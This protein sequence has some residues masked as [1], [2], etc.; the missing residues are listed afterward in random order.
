MG[1]L[2]PAAAVLRDLQRWMDSIPEHLRVEA[3]DTTRPAFQRP[4][5]VLHAMFHYTVTV[6][7]R[8]AL[9]ARASI[10]AKEGQDSTNP[11]LISMARSYCESGRDLG[12]IL[13]RLESFGKFDAVTTCDIWYTLASSS[14]LVLD[15]VCLDK[16]ADTDS[17]ES[18]VL[19]SQLA[20]LAQR[21]RRNPYMPGTIEKFAS[22][23]PELHSMA[24]SPDFSPSSAIEPGG[25]ANTTASGN[26][27]HAQ[28]QQQQD[29]GSYPYLQSSTSNGAYLFA[30]NVPG[31]FQ[32]EQAYAGNAV[33]PNARFDRSTPSHFMDF[34]M[35]NIHDWNWGNL[36]SLLGNE[37]VPIVHAHGHGHV[38]PGPPVG[39]S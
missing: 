38:P 18:S 17:S 4:L 14:V 39:P 27:H 26:L 9:L 20:D 8:A 35:N 30:D 6:L 12:R 29:L 32:A 10:L 37:A 33:Y 28:H 23:V 19:L 7:S 36:G 5:L 11:A 25:T 2:S 21:H 24:N 22:I 3:L 13:L 16:L 15:L 1:P 34:T 31:R